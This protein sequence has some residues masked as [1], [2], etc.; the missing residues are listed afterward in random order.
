M[1]NSCL[2]SE[3]CTLFQAPDY[4]YGNFSGWWLAEVDDREWEPYVNVHRWDEELRAARFNGVRTTMLESAEPWQ[5][6][7]TIVIQ[8]R[9]EEVDMT[10]EYLL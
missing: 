8:K 2:R 1:T 10:R 9:V 6:C 5:Y 7:T 4:L 3:F